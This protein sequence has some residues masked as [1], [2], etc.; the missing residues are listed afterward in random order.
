MRR[1]WG[2]YIRPDAYMRWCEADTELDVFW[3]YDTG[4][5]PLTK[6]VRKMAGYGRLARKPP[7]SCCSLSILIFGNNLVRK[8]ASSVST[9]SVPM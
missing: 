4:T 3:E 9:W 8:L 1:R 2:R 6:V 5:E 7:R